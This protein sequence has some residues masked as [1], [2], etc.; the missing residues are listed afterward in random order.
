M[1]FA[2]PVPSNATQRVVK[3]GME[4]EKL[5][6]EL[7]FPPFANF[8]SRPPPRTRKKAQGKRPLRQGGEVRNTSPSSLFSFQRCRDI[9]RIEIDYGW[10]VQRGLLRTKENG[11]YRTCSCRGGWANAECILS[12]HA[13]FAVSYV[14]NVCSNINRWNFVKYEKVIICRVSIYP[15]IRNSPVNYEFVNWFY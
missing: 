10:Q 5:G 15:W 9:E 3:Q 7:L 11:D 8:S 13:R 14:W 4:M 12:L 2:K 6:N 1:H